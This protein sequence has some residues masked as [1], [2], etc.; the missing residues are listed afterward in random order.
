MQSNK[1][2][3]SLVAA[4]F[5]V[6]LVV[7]VG[8]AL[9]FQTTTHPDN[10]MNA[11]IQYYYKEKASGQMT[12][13]EG[14]VSG[15]NGEDLLLQSIH[16]LQTGPS[17]ELLE[18]TVP[19]NLKVLDIRLKNNVAYVNLSEN[20]SDMKSGE[21]ILCRAGIVWTLT[22][23]EFVDYVVIEVDGEELTKANGDPIGKMNRDDIVLDIEVSPEPTNLE[24]VTLYFSNE[25][26][27][28]LV[29]EDREIE[30]NPNQP[31]ERYV[32]EQLIAGPQEEGH[33]MTIP[34]E[35]K[36]REINT[37][38]GI[39]YVDLSIEF[40]TKHAGGSTGEG[41]TIY[42]IVNSLT[43]LNHI[44]KVQFLIEGERQEEYKGHYDLSKPFAPLDFSA[45]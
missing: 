34:Q 29:K 44:D 22:S 38:D 13:V 30:V 31:L 8:V 26:G 25:D 7:V 45:E 2:I 9:F 18:S 17:G 21:E 36:I 15:K 39:C 3:S 5:A 12:A 4:I 35:T 37:I 16:A 10:M 19:S 20:Y 6:V 41:L 28:A 33:V 11:D 24:T 27:T 40:V 32:L 14:V 23:L 42:S 1:K 43:E